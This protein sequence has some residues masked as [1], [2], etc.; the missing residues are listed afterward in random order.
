MRHIY[1]NTTLLNYGA[2]IFLLYN[3][4]VHTITQVII[5]HSGK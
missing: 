4:M 5:Q 3:Q 2:S 1:V